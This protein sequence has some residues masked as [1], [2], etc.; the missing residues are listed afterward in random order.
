MSLYKRF[1]GH[2]PSPEAL[3]KKG[4][5]INHNTNFYFRTEVFLGFIKRKRPSATRNAFDPKGSII[6]GSFHGKNNKSVRA[7]TKT[8]FTINCSSIKLVLKN[9]K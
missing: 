8:K 1:R 2:E 5:T 6:A 9:S 7:K 4:T 3:L